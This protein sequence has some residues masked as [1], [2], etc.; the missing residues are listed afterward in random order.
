MN[1]TFGETT[2]NSIYNTISVVSYDQ[3][4]YCK[5][6]KEYSKEL[7]KLKKELEEVYDLMKLKESSSGNSI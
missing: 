6:D 4:E 7:I 1:K 3:E 5:Q 2:F